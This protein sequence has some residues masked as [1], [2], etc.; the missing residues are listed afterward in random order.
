MAYK[1]IDMN[2]SNKRIGFYILN[3][4][5]VILIGLT[6]R[7]FTIIYEWKKLNPKL[8]IKTLLI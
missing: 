5:N 4:L 6:V 2:T 3:C 8:N 1:T 7:N